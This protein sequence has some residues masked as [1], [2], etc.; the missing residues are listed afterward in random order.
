V[1]FPKWDFKRNSNQYSVMNI[2]Q[3]KKSKFNTK[4]IH[5]SHM[6]NKKPLRL[7]KRLFGNVTCFKNP[8]MENF[9]STRNHNIPGIP[10]RKTHRRAFISTGG[11]IKDS[12]LWAWV[13]TGTD[14]CWAIRQTPQKRNIKN[15]SMHYS[16]LNQDNPP[17]L[18]E[19]AF[20]SH[21]RRYSV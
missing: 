8:Y 6:A 16:I 18:I 20:F 7:M 13:S 12:G 9:W 10:K 5:S 19:Q 4:S 17:Y 3:K 1:L 2:T 14:S 11:V 21:A 15:K